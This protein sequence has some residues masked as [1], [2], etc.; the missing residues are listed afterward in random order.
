[1]D[2]HPLYLPAPYQDSVESGRLILRDGSTATVRLA[3]PS[4]APALERLFQAL[5]LE[6]RLHRFFSMAQPD[7]NFTQV[8]CDSSNPRKQLTLLV[9]RGMASTEKVIAAGSYF[10]RSEHA[11]EVAMA[12]DDAFQGKGIGA[13]LLERLALLASRAGFTRFWAITQ[14]D[15]RGMIE[16]FRHSGFPMTETVDGSYLELDFSVIPTE[17]SVRL[18]EIR[19]RVVT[20]AS[21]RSFFKPATVAVI[22]ASRNPANIGRRI[23]RALINDGFLGAVYP[24]NPAADVV[25][26][27]RTYGSVAEIPGA[28][29]LAIVA[30]PQAAILPIV[31]ECA[32]KGV[33]ALMVITAGFAEVGAEGAAI[34][35]Q[36]VEKVRASGMRM[37]G[38]N[39]MGLVN[40]DPSIRLNASFS[41]VF[42]PSGSIAMS[43]QS[44]ALGLAVL[45]LAAD[46]QLGISTFVSVGNKA[47]VSGNDLLQYWETDE[48]TNVILL[49]LESFG[50]PRRFARIARRV[51]RTKPIVVLKAGRTSGG[52]RAAGSHTAAL[53]ASETA[54]DAL[55]QQ[56]GII[57]ADTLNDMFDIAAGLSSQPLPKGR[58]TA[59]VTNAGGPAILCT[60]ACEAD[61]LRTP[62]LSDDLKT[63]LR[64]FLPATASVLNPVDMIASAGPDAYRQVIAKVLPAAEVDALIVIYIPLEKEGSEATVDAICEGVRLGRAAGGEGKPVLACLMMKNAPPALPVDDEIVPV[65]AFPESA[66]KVLAKAAKYA[67]W[68]ALPPAVVPGFAGIQLDSA[69]AAVKHALDARGAGWLLAEESSILLTAFGIAQAPGALAHSSEEAVSLA[70]KIGFPVA[71]K[72]ASPKV[73]HKSDT[74]GVRLG[75]C[76][77]DAVRGAFKEIQ[78]PEMEGV[79]IQGMIEQGVELLVGV[80]ED[81]SF[82]PL[83]AF[84]LGG[85]HVEVLGDVCFRITPLTCDD[86]RSMVRSIRGCRLLEGYR[87]EPAVDVD[88][89][90]EL[91]LRISRMVEDIPQIREMDLNPV[92]AL[93]NGQGCIVADVRIRVAT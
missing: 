4:D 3:Q 16:V 34:Q 27:M 45:A 81:P 13:H 61:G 49:Y 72:L 53:A 52:K 88:A 42:P 35:K 59:I 74:G 39:C 91:L 40:A 7:P 12:V 10:G 92:F 50:N 37:I 19:D 20:A 2:V 69:R 80:T 68:R 24:V 55:F 65:Y 71:A 58:N 44:G 86:A 1:M 26:G 51:G 87:G 32:A 21:L 60:D 11:A 30:A 25:D 75:L 73:L 29:D 23:L 17:S 90:E 5:S 43:S 41:P 22:G 62:A 14:F 57:R 56:T 82:G 84:G 93:P 31:D 54:V 70:A 79:L 66:A 48:K 15:N 67:A 46:R 47:D 38:P 63:I 78:Q 8:L 64:S 89:I 18:S 36:L 33:K 28:I 9:L 76:D 83:I 85:I 6:S 77:A